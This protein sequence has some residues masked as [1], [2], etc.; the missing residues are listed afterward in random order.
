MLKSMY[1]HQLSPEFIIHRG[2]VQLYCIDYLS[3]A[4]QCAIIFWEMDL[5]L[6]WVTLLKIRGRSEGPKAQ[7]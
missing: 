5:E 3:N 2:L 1:N 7:I 6:L 4:A